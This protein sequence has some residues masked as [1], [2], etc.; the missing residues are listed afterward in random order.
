MLI[1]TNFIGGRMLPC[2]SRCLLNYYQGLLDCLKQD[3]KNCLTTKDYNLFILAEKLLDMP[4]HNPLKT[5]SKTIR[6]GS[7]AEII[8]NKQAPKLVFMDAVC[9]LK[10]DFLQPNQEIITVNSPLGN[11]L[12]NR[13]VGETGKFK[14]HGKIYNFEILKVFPYETTKNTFFPKMAVNY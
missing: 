14:E 12:L 9:V 13:E 1:Q 7:G 10:N 5:N 3:K 8:I 4:V 6:T 11:A 2:T